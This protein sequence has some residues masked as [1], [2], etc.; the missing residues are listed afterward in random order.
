LDA[1]AGEPDDLELAQVRWRGPLL[2]QQVVDD[3]E[4]EDRRRWA[5]AA[6]LA[7]RSLDL[8]AAERYG[9]RLLAW[10]PPASAD[11]EA[12]ALT[13]K[14]PQALAA[15]RLEGDTSDAELRSLA[16]YTL[17]LGA[18]VQA[19]L[20]AGRIE[21]EAMFS[22]M[23]AFADESGLATYEAVAEANPKSHVA[24]LLLL[25]ELRE[26]RS[27]ERAVGLARELAALYPDEPLVL[28]EVL[29]L[30]TGPEDLAEGRRLLAAARERHPNHP[31]LSDE[32]MPG[33]LTGAEDAVPPWMRD[34]DE[35][36]RQLA[37]IDVETLAA[38]QPVRRLST[39]VSAE[40]FFAASAAGTDDGSGDK[41]GVH[42]PIPGYV[43]PADADPSEGDPSRVQFVVRE[44]R[45]SRCEGLGCA[46]S[47]I[48]EW[49]GRGY[50]LFWTRDLELPAGPAVEFLV[51]DGES[52]IDNVLLPTGGNLFILLSASTP[53]DFEA[54]LPQVALLH[55]SFRPLDRVLA[56]DRAESL[57]NAGERPP[58]D[59]LRWQARR[60]LSASVTD[61]ASAKESCALDQ[62]GFAQS[63]QGLAPAQRGEL[64]LDLFLA[65][66][67]AQERRALLACQTSGDPASARLALIALLDAHAGVYEWGRAATA[68]HHAR[69]IDDTRRLLYQATEPALSD[70]RLTLAGDQPAF[71]LLQVIAALPDDAARDLTRELLGRRDPR[72]RALALAATATMDDFGDPGAQSRTDPASLREVVRQGEAKDAILA[73]RSVMEIPG[74]DNLAAL[75][76]RADALIRAGAQDDGTRALA[77][78]LAWALGQRLEAADQKRIAK[79]ATAVDL[80]PA[81]RETLAAERT[82]EAIE[83]LGEDFAEGRKLLARKAPALNAETPQRWVRQLRPRPAPRSR[84]LLEKTPLA[85]LLP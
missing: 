69:V 53:D 67:S 11:D 83:D 74:A 78:E 19:D 56:A 62:P 66:H 45:A 36:A 41:L 31:W 52:I 47:L 50:T 13:S 30:L 6:G 27:R 65:S 28:A 77:L 7:L 49:Q 32:A 58:A 18:L 20:D 2:R 3:F 60:T 43:P 8:I 44:P 72:L 61:A 68:V 16:L 35:F 82:R 33:V 24:K 48:G 80:D 17:G 37:A 25:G 46:E 29:P 10:L 85:E 15:A 23:D 55:D 22:L 5:L 26:A 1:F 79:L 75:R 51:G 71:G 73:V 84:E 76:E 38:L 12:P 4:L 42:E 63:W 64:L 39:K 14:A 59:I 57:R 34:G 70:P 40:A 81:D 9:Q 21:R 54:F